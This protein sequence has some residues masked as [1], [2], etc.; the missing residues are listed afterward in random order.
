VITH[1]FE[2]LERNGQVPR[3]PV[4]GVDDDNIELTS[5]HILKQ[6]AKLRATIRFFSPSRLAIIHVKGLQ[7]PSLRLTMP[8]N[9]APLRRD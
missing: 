7:C 6:L 3:P 1:V 8:L 4:Q 9:L 2:G 5:I